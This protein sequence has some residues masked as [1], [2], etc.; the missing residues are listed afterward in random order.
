[1]ESDHG[2]GTPADQANER[3]RALADAG[4][5]EEAV[6]QYRDAAKLAP[7]WAVPH[8]NIALEH[9]RLGNWRK[10][11]EAGLRACE[12]TPAGSEACWWNLGIA[13]TALQ[14]WAT[15]RH[16]WRSFGIKVPEGDG[17]LE[18]NLGSVPIRIA[19]DS[20]TEVV[21]C[22]RIDPA[23]A[24]ILSIPLIESGHRYGDLVLHDGAPNGHRKLGERQVPVFDELALL[25]SSSFQTHEVLVVCPAPS[26]IT[27]LERLVANAGGAFEDWTQSLSVLCKQCSEGTPHEHHDN[28]G[29]SWKVER[30]CAFALLPDVNLQSLLQG[31]VDGGDG[32][33]V[34]ISD[35][36]GT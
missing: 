12:L 3:G 28:Q 9:K 19:N 14:D 16:A 21:W 6:K 33:S 22:Q 5:F 7:G 25:E 24:R 35:E 18:M 32:R 17:P 29:D 8:Y 34:N 1:M 15:A 10:S 27:D 2:P 36:S 31:W 26:D 30:Q 13:A 23:R 20:A 4:K 11:Y